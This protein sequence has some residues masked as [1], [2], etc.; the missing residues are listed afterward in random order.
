MNETLDQVNLPADKN[1]RNLKLH[2]LQTR[3]W[4]PQPIDEV[5]SFFSDALNLDELTPPW[6]HFKVRTPAPIEMRTGALIDYRIKVRGLPMSWRSEITTWDPPHRFVDEQRKGPYAFWYHQHDFQPVDGGT[7]I[8]DHVWFK[9]RGGFLEPWIHRFWVVRDL[10]R[11]FGYRVDHLA[12]RYGV[13]LT[14]ANR[15]VIIED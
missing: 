10:K 6:L 15:K 13:K 11:I 12:H 4:V 7:A 1:P 3:V 9:A 5:F 2:R 8:S 14:D